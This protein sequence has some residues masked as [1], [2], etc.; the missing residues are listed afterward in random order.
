MLAMESGEERHLSGEQVEEYCLGRCAETERD[1]WD[2]HLLVCSACREQV[3]GND[4]WVAAVRQAAVRL[5]ER[6]R[7]IRR[8]F[9]VPRLVPVFAALVVLVAIGL[10]WMR[11]GLTGGNSAPVAVLLTATRGPGVEIQAPASRPLALTPN[12]TGLPELPSYR[13]EVVDAN[14]KRMWQGLYP[15]PAAPALR[16]GLYFVRLYSTAGELYREYGLE[17]RGK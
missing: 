14:G 15:G 1:L 11:G 4:A 5:E 9:S 10:V 12:L 13:L 6:P 16:P 8:W 2:E 17:V 3:E 7:D